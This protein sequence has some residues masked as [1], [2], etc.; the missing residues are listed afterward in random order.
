MLFC[1]VGL[2]ANDAVAQR[3]VVTVGQ[4][5]D[6]VP[7]N[8]EF[9][10]MLKADRDGNLYV[11]HGVN[12]NGHTSF[13][14]TRRLF[15]RWDELEGRLNSVSRSARIEDMEIDSEGRIVVLWGFSE[16]ATRHF[17]GR[18]RVSR[19]ENGFWVN[20]GDARADD[21]VSA[22]RGFLEIDALDQPIVAWIGESHSYVK[23]FDGS[24]WL[25]LTGDQGRLPYPVAGF[26]IGTRRDGKELKYA[27][28]APPDKS[29]QM[30]RFNGIQWRPLGEPISLPS[31]SIDQQSAQFQLGRNNRIF[32]FWRAAGSGQRFIPWFAQLRG[33][34]W[35]YYE[36]SGIT[37]RD[38]VMRIRGAKQP[39][40][41]TISPPALQNPRPSTINVFV[42]EAE[43]GNVSLGRWVQPWNLDGTTL[44]TTHGIDIFRIFDSRSTVA[45]PIRPY[46]VLRY[47]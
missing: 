36:T 44:V 9:P 18:L 35:S 39:I 29:L 22:G 38:G 26:Q 14:V 19:F 43:L 21:N 34:Q 13:Y 2:L 12:R 42:R 4:N 5:L 11:I 45:G 33:Q 37:D 10:V 7:D 3:S 23:Y 6:I 24:Q 16:S 25:P 41:V 15:R 32:V 31:T 47:R 28:L 20:L 30:Y 27:L 1:L 40:F 46:Q 8:G 17:R